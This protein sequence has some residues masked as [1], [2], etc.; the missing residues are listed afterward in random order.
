MGKGITKQAGDAQGYIHPGP[1]Q[2]LQGQ[3][4]QIH[5]PPG[6]SIPHRAHSHQGQGL[7]D[8]LAA[9]AHRG[10]TPHREGQV[11][12]VIALALKVIL[13]K[14][15]GAAAAEI[16]GGFGGKAA[17]IHAV[18]VPAGGEHIGTAPAGG[19]AGAGSD[20]A[21]SETGEQSVPFRRGAGQQVG[22]EPLPDGTQHAARGGA[23]AGMILD[24]Q[25]CRRTGGSQCQSQLLLKKS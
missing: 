1:V 11:A 15:F 22:Q 25:C 3:H 8:V 9:V 6:G 23:L 10:G 24:R 12:Q 21:T 18:E 17:Q 13:Q 20:A 4:L 16:P 5:H 7:A 2:Q 14:Q 19:S